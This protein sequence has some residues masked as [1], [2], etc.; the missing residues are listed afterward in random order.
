M[1]T[2]SNWHVLYTRPRWERKVYNTLRAC[3]IDAFLPEV[4]Q[5][6]QWSDRKKAVLMPLFP[7]YVFFSVNSS[8]HLVDVL[9]TNGVIK[10]IKNDKNPAKVSQE[11]IDLIKE[12]ISDKDVK[13]IKCEGWKINR[14]EIK[15]IQNGP[16]MGYDCEILDVRNPSKI[17]VRINSLYSGVTAVLPTSYF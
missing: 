17:Y 12:M 6:R 13:E 3:S 14:G 7:S 10:L 2:S 5:D 15:T 16:L 1:T 11:E 9:R 8:S 4:K